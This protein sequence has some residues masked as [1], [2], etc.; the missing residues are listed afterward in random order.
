[1]IVK[2]RPIERAVH[3]SSRPRDS[4]RARIALGPI[5]HDRWLTACEGC[6]IYHGGCH[7]DADPTRHRRA[8]RWA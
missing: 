1:M 4:T 3:L 2:M 5:R 6:A 7:E 8:L